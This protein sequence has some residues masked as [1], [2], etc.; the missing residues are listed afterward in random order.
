MSKNRYSA[1]TDSNQKDIVEGLRR[2]GVSVETDHDDLIIGYKGKTHWIEVKTPDCVS[3]KTGKILD[4]AKKP[5]QIKLE[6][7]FKGSYHIVTSIGE[8][9][10]IIK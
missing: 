6:N 10:E 3:K 7:E 5:S 8:I 4:S 9:L 1:R 2:L